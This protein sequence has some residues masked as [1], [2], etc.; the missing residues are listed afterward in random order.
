MGGLSLRRDDRES[1]SAEEC[2]VF[3]GLSLL[4]IFGG[5][6]YRSPDGHYRRPSIMIRVELRIQCA[7]LARRGFVPFS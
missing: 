2:R 7:Q 1:V 4:G 6:T 5:H 3:P